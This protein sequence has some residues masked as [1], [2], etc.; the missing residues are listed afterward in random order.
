ML[1]DQGAPACLVL[2]K[3]MPGGDVNALL[4]KRLVQAACIRELRGARRSRSSDP[5][6]KQLPRKP[7]KRHASYMSCPA[8]LTTTD[9]FV[10]RLQAELESERLIRDPMRPLVLAALFR[11]LSL[12]RKWASLLAQGSG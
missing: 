11:V 2:S 5:R 7:I 4:A 12:G 1:P 9:V 6:R 3:L 10:N 8:E